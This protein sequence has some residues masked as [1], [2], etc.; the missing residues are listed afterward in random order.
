[1]AATSNRLH[2]ELPSGDPALLNRIAW[3][4]RWSERQAS[5]DYALAARRKALDGVGRRSRA[6]QGFALRTL[7]WQAL[8]R[9][10]LT[11]SMD[12]C[13]QAEALLP[14]LE[15]IQERAGIYSNLAIIHYLRNRFDLAMCAV[16]RGLW[17]LQDESE[18]TT[19]LAD[20]M[21]TQANIQRL[22]G[23]RA[24]AGITLGRARELASGEHVAVV[25]IATASL[26]IEDGDAEKALEYAEAAV[27][28][29]LTARDPVT[30]PYGRSILADCHTQLGNSLAA[31][32][33]ITLGMAELDREDEQA[34]PVPE[35]L[36]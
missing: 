13:L 34:L 1:M 9:G 29:I 15:F 4:R 8:W 24:R 3:S 21:I 23:E 18:D 19:T 32:E 7:G 10:D 16:E 22:S 5:V 28:A 26:L 2:S 12:Y 36:L 25:D 35:E 31:V 20:L 11:L 33:Q 17:L 27:N 6:E 14:E 30:L